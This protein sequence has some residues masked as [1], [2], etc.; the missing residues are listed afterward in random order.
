MSTHLLTRAGKPL[1]RYVAATANK[2]RYWVRQSPSILRNRPFTSSAGQ[3]QRPVTGD[4]RGRN[5]GGP[6]SNTGS[7]NDPR[8]AS[9]WPLPA[10]VTVAVAA[11]LLGWA[12][13]EIR[14]GSFP[15]TMLL[16][17][18]F[19]MPSYASMPEMEQVWLHCCFLMSDP[20][21]S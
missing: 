7:N 19:P 3:L 10:I 2:P 6:D 21:L 5:R 15:G 13:S 11:G 17:S 1:G 20:C 16:D 12:I 9:A 4:G 18:L 14:H 8:F